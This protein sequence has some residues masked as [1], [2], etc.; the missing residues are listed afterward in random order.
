MRALSH[1][2]ERSCIFSLFLS[3]LLLSWGC[4]Y[5]LP[6][7]VG[8]WPNSGAQLAKGTS[9]QFAET[10]RITAVGYAV[11]DTQ[12]GQSHPQRRLMAIRASKLDAYRNMAEKV[13]GVFVESTS[14]SS[15]MAITNE[16]IR[17]RVQGLIYGSELESIEPIGRDS[18]Q[19]TLSL[20]VAVVQELLARYRKSPPVKARTRAYGEI[21]ANAKAEGKS[22]PENS[23]LRWNFSSKR[24]ERSEKRVS[25]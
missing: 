3:A 8:S 21:N 23:R 14:Q 7:S 2:I 12:K 16:D 24:W 5:E 9:H 15:E 13:Y 20:E 6:A 10:E 18:Y 11:I 22:S 1:T 19:T 25:G 17:G 4:A